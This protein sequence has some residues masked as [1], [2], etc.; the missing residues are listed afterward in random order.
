MKRRPASPDFPRLA[1]RPRSP[2]QAL[3]AKPS[4]NS[5]NEKN[6]VKNNSND[7]DRFDSSIQAQVSLPR[8]TAIDAH[9][10]N[11]GAT[12]VRQKRAKQ[13]FEKNQFDLMPC[14]DDGGFVSQETASPSPN[15]VQTSHH[16]NVESD[17]GSPAR[18]TH[19]S[20]PKVS[21]RD[22]RQLNCTRV[23]HAD[24]PHA[25]PLSRHKDIGYPKD[26]LDEHT[27][28]IRE[29]VRDDKKND[30]GFNSKPSGSDYGPKKH[31]LKP[32]EELPNVGLGGES[33]S[34]SNT[35][36]VKGGGLCGADQKSEIEG[37][38]MAS[39]PRLGTDAGTTPHEP[40]TRR[41]DAERQGADSL[42]NKVLQKA[43][44]RHFNV[45]EVRTGSPRNGNGVGKS[46]SLPRSMPFGGDSAPALENT[47]GETNFRK[48]PPTDQCH[49]NGNN[50]TALGVAAEER[51]YISK[52]TL[53]NARS[54]GDA[55]T[56][57]DHGNRERLLNRSNE[58]RKALLTRHEAVELDEPR[59]VENVLLDPNVESVERV[60]FMHVDN[61]QGEVGRDQDTCVVRLELNGSALKEA[62]DCRKRKRM[63]NDGPDALSEPSAGKHEMSRDICFGIGHAS[64]MDGSNESM[65]EMVVCL[66]QEDS[67][68]KDAEAIRE[69]TSRLGGEIVSKF[70]VTKPECVVTWVGTDRHLDWGSSKIVGAARAACVPV[71][72]VDWIVQSYWSGCWLDIH[73]FASAIGGQAEKTPLFE[74]V[75]VILPS[76]TQGI[77]MAT[78]ELIFALR[79]AGAKIIPDETFDNN[80]AHKIRVRIVNFLDGDGINCT[81]NDGQ[82]RWL[83][84]K[85]LNK[86]CAVFLEANEEW[87]WES[88]AEGRLLGV[89]VSESEGATS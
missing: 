78:D 81:Q 2:T 80:D 88:M 62:L 53:H 67:H 25:L 57:K 28:G 84:K 27:I 43:Q 83:E 68:P 6:D 40:K 29:R 14:V 76:S 23:P 44:Y 89:D 10:A 46:S 13:S 20:T 1:K 70:D 3:L 38:A 19:Q 17:S 12:A 60:N 49:T 42:E 35:D 11:E 56:I 74:K 79:A 72:D 18:A 73:G 9:S 24:T 30:R 21:P 26:R 85:E 75:C 47:E 45:A 16:R 77:S 58:K 5:L 33:Q 39:G 36:A 51:N 48:V 66:A 82:F 41:N 69:I 63:K 86:G 64:H 4:L 59:E 7:E 65:N 31:I 32:N 54:S 71:V 87:V 55:M 52:E 50:V 34:K 15:Q 8:S 22:R 37:L 61:V